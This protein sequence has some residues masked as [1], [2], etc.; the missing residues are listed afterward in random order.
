MSSTRSNVLRL[1]V[2]GLLITR[3][4]RWAQ[5]MLAFMLLGVILTVVLLALGLATHG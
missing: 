1:A 3:A 5:R 4:P 2:L